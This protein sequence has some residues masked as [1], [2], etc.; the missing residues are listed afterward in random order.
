MLVS[1][2]KC[3]RCEEPTN[4]HPTAE[5]CWGCQQIANNENYQRQLNKRRLLK[6]AC[7]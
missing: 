1:K 7:K 3:K 2:K 5:Y 6:K 4:R